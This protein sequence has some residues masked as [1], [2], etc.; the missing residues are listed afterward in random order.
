MATFNRLR[1]V[2]KTVHMCSKVMEHPCVL[3]T[4]DQS[5][6]KKE[7]SVLSS[8]SEPALKQFKAKF[9]D[10]A[11]SLLLPLVPSSS[12]YFKMAIFL[13]LEKGKMSSLCRRF[14]VIRD[15]S[16]R[17]NTKAFNSLWLLLSLLCVCSRGVPSLTE[18]SSVIR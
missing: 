8:T 11:T 13:S 10:S 7:N 9:R 14:C 6:I 4:T 5:C 3:K 16:P 12:L 2:C 15:G 18:P 1:C 17:R